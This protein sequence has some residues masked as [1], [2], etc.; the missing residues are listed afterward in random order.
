MNMTTPHKLT[1]F[2]VIDPGPNVLLEVMRAE[3]PVVAVERLEGKMRGP[4]YVA[5]R[6][7]D[8]GGEE[9]LDGADPAYLVYELDDSGLDAEGL[10]GEDAGQVRAQA[11]LAAVVVSSAK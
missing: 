9:S 8:V 6:S 4:E 5:A 10:T 11:D 3:S 2:A 7:Y 1:T